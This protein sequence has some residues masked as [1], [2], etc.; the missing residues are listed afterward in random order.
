MK[1]IT[2][3]N[4][5][6]SSIELPLKQNKPVTIQRK[7]ISGSTYLD[8]SKYTRTLINQGLNKESLILE[9]K[10]IVSEVPESIEARIV[11]G[12]YYP[13]IEMLESSNLSSS[14]APQI[15][16]MEGVGDGIY[17]PLHYTDR[18]ESE[19]S[20]EIQSYLKSFTTLDIE[21]AQ[22]KNTLYEFNSK[23]LNFKIL[24]KNVY[25]ILEYS[26]FEMSSFISTP[27]FNITPKNVVINLFYFVLNS[28]LAQK[29]FLLLNL[30]KLQGLSVKLSKYFKKP[31]H[32]ELTQLYSISNNSQIL[33]NILGKLGLSRRNSFSRIINKFLKY[34]SNKILFRKNQNRY[35]KF[36][37][38]LTGINIKLGGRLM[39]G[40]IIPRKSV[41]KIQYGSLA[42]SKANYIT[43]ARLTQKNKRGSFS[44]TVSIGHKFF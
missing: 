25:K 38:I 34:Q 32:L 7:V 35:S 29:N 11:E 1:S 3:V 24:N 30:N 4:N 44:F 26:F 6:Y 17:V 2:P 36:A 13:Q 9:S 28:K 14:L 12:Q 21:L 20:N 8:I 31:V 15:G 40:K 10:K 33:V 42:R 23:S 27:Q 39:R 43:T 16:N 19:I 41:R 5:H 37:T 18:G 22:N